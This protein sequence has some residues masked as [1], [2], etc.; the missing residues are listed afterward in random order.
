MPGQLHCAL[1]H[2]ARD[3]WTS[4]GDVQKSG[5]RLLKPALTNDWDGCPG[6]PQ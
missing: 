4:K 2:S 5:Y 1:S 6:S 3:G